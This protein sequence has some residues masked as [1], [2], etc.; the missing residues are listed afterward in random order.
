MYPILALIGTIIVRYTDEFLISV[1]LHNIALQRFFL[2]IWPMSSL[3]NVILPFL[4][5]EFGFTIPVRWP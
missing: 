4:A 3:K 5:H 2:A 1:N